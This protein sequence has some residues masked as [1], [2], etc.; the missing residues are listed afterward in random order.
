MHPLKEMI[1]KRASGSLCG[2]YS[3]C[4]ANEMVVEAA[5][6]RAKANDEYA[7]IEA[8][9]NQVNQDGGY[10]GMRPS[11]FRDFVFSVADRVG[12]PR[13]KIILGGDHLG[14]LTWRKLPAAKALE[15]AEELIWQFVQSGYTKIHIDT[16]MYLGDDDR[17]RGLGNETI[18]DR[19]ARLAA[20]AEKAYA[21]LSRSDRG[22]PHP[23]YVVGSE[24]PIPGGSQSVEDTL[25]VTKPRDFIETLEV[26][27]QTFKER[28]LEGAWR[29]VV[30]FV[31]Q[32][33]VEFGDETVH[34]YDKQA[35]SALVCA[36]KAY[37]SLVFEGHSTD[38]QTPQGLRSM[39]E[40][41]IAILKV[42]P[43]LTFALREALVALNLIEEE[44]L[45]DS[46]VAR[47]GFRRVL[48]ERMLAE[49]GYWKDHY[50]GEPSSL[51]LARLYSYSDRCR[52][53]LPDPAVS[54]AINRLIANLGSR[55]I[56]MTLLS[57]FL[58][59]QYR[60]VLG[61]RLENEA[62]SLLVDHVGDCI[63]D[64]RFAVAGTKA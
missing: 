20:V 42:G 3:A 33:G 55:P 49:P 63:D 50:H 58:P 17:T 11:D 7:L 25:R 24:V 54:R 31:V 6:S 2:V 47:S 22:A 23:V 61:G 14:P 51:R 62:R 45:A 29:Q 41:G 38:Y 40:D 32:P 44:L 48:E 59:S 30:A 13:R 64:Y 46:P 37:P 1:E 53:Y 56:P 27:Q 15:K 19:G 43:A 9:A 5:L 10:T 60:K 16:S 21:E 12:M 35:A 39:V 36:L 28:S 26:F 57:Q 4:S 34:H 8:T 52:Y 18:A